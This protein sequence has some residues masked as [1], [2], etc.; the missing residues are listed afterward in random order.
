VIQDLL[1]AAV[2]EGPGAWPAAAPRPRPPART[3]CVLL[4][5]WGTEFIGQFLDYSLPTLLAPGNIPALAK[6]LATRFVFLTRAADEA[7]FRAHPAFQHLA[8]V[9]EVEFSPIDDLITSGNHSTTITLAYARAVRATGSAMRDTCF[10]FLVSDYIMADGSLAAVLRR[11]QAGASAV[12]V[13]NFQLMEETAESWLDR[14]FAG[15]GVSLAL[16]A[17][18]LM[19]WG[20]DCLHPITLANMVNFPLCHNPEAN[21][22]LWRVDDATLIGRFYLLHMICIR[23]EL[24]EF[25]VGSSCDYSFIPEMCPSGNVVTITDSDDYLVVEVQP[26]WH[27]SNFLR[28]GPGS[29]AELAKK[30][31]DW[32]T[33]GHRKNARDTIVFHA[34]EPPAGLAG[35][36]AE[37]DRY[38]AE[39]GARLAMT[40]QPHRDHPYW[41][42][43]LAAFE[44]AGARRGIDEA[45]GASSGAPRYSVGRA[46]GWLQNKLFG[47]VP[48]VTRA[49]PRWRDLQSPLASD[50]A[51]LGA[52]GARV[53]IA[54]N[55]TTAVTDWA[56]RRVPDA[57]FVSLRRLQ[58]P[59][60]V[61]GLAPGC[62]DA[63][64]IELVD[65]DFVEVGEF[66]RLLMPLLRPGAE[67][68]LI[69]FNQSWTGGSMY[70]GQILASYTTNLADR[71]L[72]PIDVHI[73]TA[74]RFR[75]WVNGACVWLAGNLFLRPAVLLPLR[76]AV[77]V[78]LLPLAVGLNLVS[79]L[80]RDHKPGERVTSSVF[81]RYRVGRA[82]PIA[83]PVRETAIGL[84][85]GSR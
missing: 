63:C 15:A 44:A 54:A 18:E 52:S 33:A 22:L 68:L 27:E 80:R 11:M 34:D 81:V 10:F 61:P 30:L 40:P 29:V 58:R 78:L 42:G 1:P 82:A 19:R 45:G 72:W 8:T 64:L 24:S 71:G 56:R 14:R 50:V 70:F 69:A 49:H 21:R 6:A 31:S 51:L 77:S 84:T 46:L 39:I 47:L 32:T 9:T 38:I 55:R 12:Q 83:E 60:P 66:F 17:R 4:P 23:P 26:R 37:A 85:A 3:I 2:G 28:V 35:A 5:V 53:L 57:V 25:I 36:I 67:M 59:R 75:W 13:G 62:F 20:L 79:S 16:T 76:L 41:R 65:N 74:S 73:G 43:A 7:K 48:E